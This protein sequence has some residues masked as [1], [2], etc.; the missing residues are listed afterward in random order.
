MWH[1]RRA[2]V[3]LAIAFAAG[4]ALPG[5]TPAG[6]YT[7]PPG[8]WAPVWSPDGDR[9]A[10]FTSRAG[11]GLAIIP[12]AGG[13]D[14]PLAEGA[15]PYNA[16]LSPDWQWVATSLYAN[17][18]N[19][20]T[21]ARLDGTQE[22]FLTTT[23][24]GTRPAWSP[25]SKEIAFQAA[26]KSLAV[27][28]VEG[29][30]AKHFAPGGS[31]LAW[32]PDGTRIA[33]GGGEPN[34]IDLH[35]A[36]PATGEV[37]VLAGGPGQQLEPKW[38]PDGKRIAFLTQVRY[39]ERLRIGVIRPDGTDLVIYPGP[40]FTD[41]DS[42]AW[43]PSSRGIVFARDVAQGIYRLDLETGTVV[44]LTA[45]GATPAPSPDGQVIAFAGG[46]E[47][48][49]RLGVYVARSDGTAIQRLTNDCRVLGTPH[50]D[51]LRGTDLADVLIGLAGNDRLTGE[52]T[53]YVGDTLRGGVGD[54][55]LVGTTSGDLLHGGNGADR[56]FGGLSADVLYGGSGEDR[57]DA[58]AGRDLVHARDGA[59]DVVFCG[60]D[61]GGAPER[62]EVWA[63]R[64]DAVS[65]DCEV[66]HRRRG[67]G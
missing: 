27:I 46:G 58:Q 22:R 61:R 21:V 6:S 20:L 15:A 12:A 48:R 14:L 42:F 40:G 2:V 62:D 52:S 28:G 35:V 53:G 37:R 57:I 16:A 29:G 45:F 38:S 54:D 47:C 19:R 64:I 9:I 1:V 5:A 32:S 7:L 30:A 49:D 44:R 24:F 13:S 31:W 33:F 65:A 50:D 55:V 66:V 39:G 11:R 56:L 23:E 17:G 59:R 60:T 41:S 36:D 25:D 8:D 26:G 18:R 3:V 4:S 34:D 67:R 51:A 10:F 63:D 43:L